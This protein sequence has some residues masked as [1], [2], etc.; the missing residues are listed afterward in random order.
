M[1]AA[2]GSSTMSLEDFSREVMGKE[3]KNR[4][5]L[6]RVTFTDDS[7]CSY[8]Q[9]VM[10][11]RLPLGVG[12]ALVGGLLLVAWATDDPAWAKLVE[13]LQSIMNFF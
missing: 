9:Q 8:D 4:S 1:Y 3:P 5:W 11:A 10:V 6:D 7:G 12:L 2:Q 13:Q